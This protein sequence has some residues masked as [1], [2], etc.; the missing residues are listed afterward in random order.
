LSVHYQIF[1]EFVIFVFNFMCFLLLSLITNL[2]RTAASLIYATATYVAPIDR[3]SITT[4]SAFATHSLVLLKIVPFRLVFIFLITSSSAILNI[5]V[6]SASL[7][8]QLLYM[9]N[10]WVI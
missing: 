4:S 5:V 6:D 3:L 8:L 7:C 9:P 1:S 10:T 2:V